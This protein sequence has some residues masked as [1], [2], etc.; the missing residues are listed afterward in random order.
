MH[1]KDRHTRWRRSFGFCAVS[2][3]AS[4]A[5]IRRQTITHVFMSLNTWPVSSSL[6]TTSIFARLAT[7]NRLCV[8]GGSRAQR[9]TD[10]LLS[11]KPWNPVDDLYRD[12]WP[13]GG[14]P[15]EQCGDIIVGSVPELLRRCDAEL[16]RKN[17]CSLRDQTRCAIKSASMSSVENKR[18][19]LTS[20]KKTVRTSGRL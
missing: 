8:F 19:I 16:F 10:Y 13:G 3:L 17:S 14:K 18:L 20:T 4:R 9:M 15:I 1:T 11:C 6:L 5:P 7:G 12:C 2:Q